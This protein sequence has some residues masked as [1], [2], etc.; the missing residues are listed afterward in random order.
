MALVVV[1]ERIISHRKCRVALLQPKRL[2]VDGQLMVILV[3]VVGTRLGF[4]LALGAVERA[5]LEV[6]LQL[7]E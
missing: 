5:R 3:V 7:I 4:K 2:P 6:T 1:L